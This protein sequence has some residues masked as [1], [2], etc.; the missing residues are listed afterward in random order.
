MNSLA[1]LSFGCGGKVTPPPNI[2]FILADDLG[3][4]DMGCYGQELIPTGGY[5]SQME[6][7]AA[8]AAMIHILDEQ[9]GQIINKIDAMGL[10]DNTIIIFTSDNGPHL[11]GG[12]DPDYFNSDG[13]LKGYKRDLYEG[14]I[15]VPMLV[16]WPEKI[17]AGSTTDHVSAFWDVLPTL[18][19]L[20]GITP[21]PNIDGISFL[22]SLTGQ[23]EQ[24]QHDYLY[25]AFYEKGGRQAILKN[26]WK[27]V[28]YDV[29]N[30]EK[31]TTVL[32]DLDVDP[33]EENN[34]ASEHPGMV[35][36]L[37]QLILETHIES[38]IWGW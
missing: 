37:K 7:H 16:R 33:G 28:L 13:P 8:F 23:N 6:S 20:T 14:G 31:T 9:V 30:P 18:S 29:L 4:G 34:L 2:V 19:E 5:E 38:D 25:W 17:K 24:K 10:R 15:R 3:Y 26:N 27:L 35:E 36:E 32:F 1:I 21:P 22:P 11:E 12:A